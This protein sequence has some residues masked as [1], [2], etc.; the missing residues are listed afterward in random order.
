M[1]PVIHNVC[2]I[3]TV[4]AAS[5]QHACSPKATVATTISKPPSHQ[6]DCTCRSIT[7]HA[8]WGCVRH[9][10]CVCSPFWCQ[11][12]QLRAAVWPAC[13][14]ARSSCVAWQSCCQVGWHVSSLAEL[15]RSMPGRPIALAGV[16]AAYTDL[17]SAGCV[18]A[19]MVH[20]NVQ[21]AVAECSAKPVAC[22]PA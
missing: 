15:D 9:K 14:A 11:A 20:P 22:R 13:A 4:R 16:G 18:L 1:R 12:L 2:H 10:P 3:N 8:G 5:P 19:S 21:V 7:A 17:A 6:S